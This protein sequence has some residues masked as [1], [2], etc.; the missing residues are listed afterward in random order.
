MNTTLFLAQIWGPIMIAMGLGFFLSQSYYVK[1][2]KNL[3]QDPFA[4]ILFG[5]IG[6]AAGLAQVLTHNAWGSFT[7]VVIS[8]LGWAL[9]LKGLFCVVIPRFV[10][11][12]GDWAIQAKIFPAS[13]IITFVLGLIISWIAYFS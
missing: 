1:I 7:E 10:E 11:K 8:L 9:L 6:M 4:V 3:E 12:S 2:Y 13:G 5:M